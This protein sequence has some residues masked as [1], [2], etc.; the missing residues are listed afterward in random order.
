MRLGVLLDG[1]ALGARCHVVYCGV[2]W[3]ER[4]TV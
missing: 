4:L 2:V 3:R 1:D